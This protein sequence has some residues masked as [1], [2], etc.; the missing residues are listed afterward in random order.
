MIKSNDQETESRILDAAREVFLR[1]GTAGARM[2][3]IA[4]EAGVNQALL[5][6]YFRSKAGLA[7]AVF[8][9]AARELFPPVLRT[10]ASEA[11]LEEKV[12][13]VV[14]IELDTLQRNPF[15]P[16]YVLSE[17]NHHPERVGQFVES[18]TGVQLDT[19]APRMFD[20][21][22]AQ[23]DEAVAAGELRP[24]AAEQFVIN[25][26]S[27]CIFPFA[28][29]PLLVAVMGM[30]DDAFGAMIERR[31]TELPEFFLRGLRP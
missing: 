3:E 17:L 5:H 25:L 26:L 23:I 11:P 10:L 1:R 30:D 21:L 8:Q 20:R 4:E 14:R 13:E 9:R 16:G 6:Y 18:M 24:I 27:L 15:L 2:A 29:R 7:E 28:A 22:G 19:V 12:R 31:K